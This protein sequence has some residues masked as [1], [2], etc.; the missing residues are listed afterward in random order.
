MPALALAATV[1][2]SGR[3][4]AWR[5]PRGLIGTLPFEARPQVDKGMPPG[6]PTQR[7]TG[8]AGGLPLAVYLGVFAM[9]LMS[10]A[11]LI[12]VFLIERFAE[13]ERREAATR[14]SAAAGSLVSRFEREV[15]NTLV[16]LRSWA[17]SN[18][19]DDDDLAGFHAWASKVL[20]GSGAHALVVDR[21]SQVL[22]H[23]RV[24]YSGERVLSADPETPQTVFRTGE[25]MV[26]GVFFGMLSQEYVFNVLYPVIRSGEVRYVLI[27]TRNASQL[28]REVISASVVPEAE[29]WLTDSSGIVLT[30]SNH[31][32]AS[33]NALS[34]RLTEAMGGDRL[35]SLI[36]KDS[37]EWVY[38][39]HLE[40]PLTGWS[41][42]V[43]VP[44]ESVDGPIETSWR[45]LGYLGIALLSAMAVM[46]LGIWWLTALPIRRLSSQA[47]AYGAGRE[48]PP[49]RGFLR[50]ANEVSAV[51]LQASE[52]RRRH[53]TSLQVLSR[54]LAHRAVNLLTV[55]QSMA[56]QTARTSET[57]AD[58][59]EAFG[60]RLTALASSFQLAAS[61][62]W[63]AVPIHAAANATLQAFNQE[64]ESR[65]TM[66]GPALTLMP[67]GAEL[68][69]LALF[70]LVTNA[71]K[72]GAL[73]VPDGHVRVQWGVDDST[74]ELELSWTEEGGPPV[75]PPTRLGLGHRLITETMEAGLRGKVVL[76]FAATGL[77]WRLQ[78]PL[79]TIIGDPDGCPD[80]VEKREPA[81][82][83]R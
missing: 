20:E 2:V 37:G 79:A 40:S 66:S 73:S 81:A 57:V 54:E 56:Q 15:D 23:T 1:L 3:N 46:S 17:A 62:N 8:R 65:I 22:L 27:I 48:I 71:V 36:Q 51:L 5:P 78:C 25:A 67:K 31:P 29:I 34:T 60:P 70:E 12:G 69:G 45:L 74:G 61:R 58:F 13:A 14:L 18:I 72:H 19:L 24:P 41:V 80:T 6:M 75:A 59:V 39:S 30:N 44:K 43:A 7:T 28:L 63:G 76:T 35:L 83:A 82:A 11:L 52:E 33:G 50:E 9:C 21:Q 32:E 68:I 26:S 47:R 49:Q 53:E 38:V 16:T 55:V 4:K 64:G 77:R 10:A 42:G